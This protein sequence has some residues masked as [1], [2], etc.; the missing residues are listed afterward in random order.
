MIHVTTVRSTVPR[1]R[2][3][4]IEVPHLPRGYRAILAGDIPG[5]KHP[6]PTGI[7]H[8]GPCVGSRQLRREPVYC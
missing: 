2:I 1:G 7:G 5:E 3:I 8:S 4:R 6:S